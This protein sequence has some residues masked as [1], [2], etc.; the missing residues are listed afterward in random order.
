MNKYLIIQGYKEDVLPLVN[1]IEQMQRLDVLVQE[2]IT[3][4][5]YEIVIKNKYVKTIVPTDEGEIIKAKILF[6]TNQSVDTLVEILELLNQ[7][8]SNIEIKLLITA[9]D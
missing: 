9:Y 3:V 6:E 2:K 7:K 4:P 1:F 8:Y 5:L